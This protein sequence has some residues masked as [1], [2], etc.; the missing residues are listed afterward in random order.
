MPSTSSSH[1]PLGAISPHAPPPAPT[2]ATLTLRS[3]AM[4]S[5]VSHPPHLHGTTSSTSHIYPPSK[6]SLKGKVR[7]STRKFDGQRC[8][9][10][11]LR[12]EPPITRSNQNENSNPHRSIPRISNSPV[13]L[14]LPNHGRM[15]ISNRHRM[16][17]DP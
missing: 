2:L 5:F 7:N 3:P 17:H 16:P 1:S 6:D 13:C 10:A 8:V 14:L 15:R 11:A 9:P 4:E 12:R